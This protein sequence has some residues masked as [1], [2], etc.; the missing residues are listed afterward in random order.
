M[1]LAAARHQGG[2]LASIY[3]GGGTPSLLAPEQVR[4]LLEQSRQLW[5]HQPGCEITL[6][7]NPGTIT[8]DSLEGFRQAGINRLSLGVQSL[9]DQ[10]LQRLG[11]PHTADQA[12]EAYVAARTAGF[13][14]IGLD[15]ICGLPHQNGEDWRILLREAIELAPEHLSIYSL[16]IEDG[17]PFSLRY[18][19]DSPDLPNDDQTAAMLELADQLLVTAGYEHYEIANFAR[20]GRRSEHNSGYWQRDGYLGIGPS[21]HSLLLQGW[22]LRCSNPADHQQWAE[23]ISNGRLAHDSTD[24]LTAAEALSELLFLGLRMADGISPEVCRQ[25]FGSALWAPHGQ[26]ID[27]LLQLGLLEERNGRVALTRRGILLSNQ[28]F[29][30]F[31]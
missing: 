22:G 12:R 16:S 14:N 25:R 29:V 6:E 24:E 7:A 15:L 18:Q 1:E 31:I 10:T 8:P 30:R 28:V 9:D 5:G 26:A 27:A 19:H 17:T 11:R 21:A 23:L 3:L 2:P 4:N 13:P 20:P